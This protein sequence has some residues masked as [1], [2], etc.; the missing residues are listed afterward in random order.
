M[1][2]FPNLWSLEP[3][4]EVPLD[5]RVSAVEIF[6]LFIKHP[7]Q[8]WRRCCV[9]S[10]YW[11]YRLTVPTELLWMHEGRCPVTNSFSPL[12][13]STESSPPVS[14]IFKISFFYSKALFAYVSLL[15]FG[16]K[17]FR[18]NVFSM[19]SGRKLAATAFVTRDEVASSH[20]CH[21]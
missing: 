9:L 16:I 18:T 14:L 5:Y 21:Q 19:C 12:V 11:C 13:V 4:P 20:S 17:L 7:Q 15:P 6:L 3:L 8:C 2:R 10:G 1:C